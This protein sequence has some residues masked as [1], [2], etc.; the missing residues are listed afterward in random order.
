MSNHYQRVHKPHQKNTQEKSEERYRVKI[1]GSDTQEDSDTSD[2]EL[3]A[4]RTKRFN[5]HSVGS[6]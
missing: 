6:V 5:F 2:Q 4:L 3:E 1:A